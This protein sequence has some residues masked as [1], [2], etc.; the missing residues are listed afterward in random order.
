MTPEL[1]RTFVNKIVIYEREKKH[2][3]MLLSRSTSTTAISAVCAGLPREQK[4]TMKRNPIHNGF[5]AKGKDGQ[6]KLSVQPMSTA[7]R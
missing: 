3:K 6:P 1:L 7:F 5:Q 2:D 4:E